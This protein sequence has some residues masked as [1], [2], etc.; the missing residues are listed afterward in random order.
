MAIPAIIHQIYLGGWN[1]VP[2]KTKD[3]IYGLRERNPGWEY[4]FYDATTS[5][6]FIRD[7]FGI[8][9][10]ATYRKIDPAYYAAKADLLRYLLCHAEGGIYLDIKSSALRPLD[11]VFRP[12]DQFLLSQWPE[13][14][15]RPA[16]QSRSPGLS[17][18]AGDEYVQWFVA[19][20][21]QHPFLSKVIDNVVRNIHSYDP[22]REGVGKLAVLRV[23]GPIAYTLAIHPIRDAHQHRY[24]DFE[25]DLGL[26]FSIHGRFDAHH[27]VYGLHYGTLTRPVVQGGILQALACKGWY[28]GINPARRYVGWKIDGIRKR[29]RR[30]SR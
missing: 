10:L 29:L 20:A 12:E 21:P 9:M 6:E 13:L 11:R 7:R 3:A 1:A 18:V 5:E 14:R 19:S 17:Q 4:R 28:G 8:E 2:E 22:F 16:E 23:T 30:Y 25:K 15:D 24:V 27:R 26:V